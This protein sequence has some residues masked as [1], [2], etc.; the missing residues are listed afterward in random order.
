MRCES[1]IV[2][3]SPADGEL[4][5]LSQDFAAERSLE[6]DRRRNG[7][8]DSELVTVIQPGIAIGIEGEDA[9][10]RPRRIDVRGHGPI[11]HLLVSG[12]PAGDN[13]WVSC[14]AVG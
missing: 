8:A 13:G 10:A 1:R 5:A 4:S 7:V 6:R 2:A 14:A 9:D 3:R 12:Q 11:K